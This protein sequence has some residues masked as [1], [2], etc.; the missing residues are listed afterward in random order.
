MSLDMSLKPFD[1]VLGRN[2]DGDPW[3]PDI[4]LRYAYDKT[5]VVCARKNWLKCVPYEEETYKMPVVPFERGEHI[6]VQENA[7]QRRAIFLQLDVNDAT[8]AVVW[9]YSGEMLQDGF[10]CV[11][12]LKECLKT[13]W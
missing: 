11:V 12:P 6:R 13:P 8:K 9:K 2:K 7:I 4:F 5:Y 10:H 1:R 3:N